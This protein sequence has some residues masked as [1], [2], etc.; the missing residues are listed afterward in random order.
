MP[1]P[2]LRFAPGDTA[3]V[4]PATIDYRVKVIESIMRVAENGVV[5]PCWLVSDE[6]GRVYEKMQL[7]LSARPVSIVRGTARLM[8]GAE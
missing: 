8:K 1:S 3:Y 6:T 7:E 5:F 2:T 4:R